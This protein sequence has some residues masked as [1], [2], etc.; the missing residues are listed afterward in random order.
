M[1]KPPFLK[2]SV[3]R[4]RKLKTEHQEYLENTKYLLEN[5]DSLK[6]IKEYNKINL[7]I[8]FGKGEFLVKQA[9]ENQEELFIGSELFLSGI[10][11]VLEQSDKQ[12][13][14]NIRIFN[15]DV[16]ILL[17][18]IKYALFDKIFILFPDPWPKTRHNR[19]R[20]VN[21]YLFNEIFRILK[22]NGQVHIVTDSNDYAEQVFKL[23]EIDSRFKPL[24]QKDLLKVEDLNTS[25][26]NKAKKQNNKI[27]IFGIYK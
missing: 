22:T 15:K 7:E 14:H 27:N 18:E 3:Q 19:R 1:I 9:L 17:S 6:N 21:D 8:G 2:S 20:I 5:L 12:N 4:N 10:A 24:N 11:Q 26:H 23:I 16:R 25:Y 13:I